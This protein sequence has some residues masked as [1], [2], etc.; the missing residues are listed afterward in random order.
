MPFGGSLL[1]GAVAAAPKLYAAYKQNRAA[2]NLKLQDTTPAAFREKA[3]LDRQAAA[4]GVM[5]GQN[6]AQTRLAG[7]QAGALQAARLGAASSGDLL[8][9]AGA[10]DAR[11][12]AGEQQLSTQAAQYG[13]QAQHVVGADLT[14]QAAYQK[15]DLDT[16]NR[17]KAALTQGSAENL[18]NAVEGAASYAAYG[19]NNAAGQGVG[20]AQQQA[21]DAEMGS[22]ELTPRVIGIDT[23]NLP[24]VGVRGYIPPAP[25]SPHRQV[26]PT[27]PVRFR[28]YGGLV[29]VWD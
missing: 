26:A 18:N 20:V 22:E 17:T 7:V 10:A 8:A 27:S 2:A 29:I 4:S 13:I 23:N 12:Q 3:A 5:P 15:N 1:L 25:T 21:Q 6:A 24:A 28:G 9:A 16:Y 11:R 19:M 14:Q